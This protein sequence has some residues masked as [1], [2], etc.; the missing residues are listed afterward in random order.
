MSK[1]QES[2]MIILSLVTLLGVPAAFFLEIT[3]E[4]NT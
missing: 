4:V 3:Q 1:K 2:I